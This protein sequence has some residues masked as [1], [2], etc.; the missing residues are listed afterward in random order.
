MVQLSISP[1][2]E[3]V[4]ISERLVAS[5]EADF[6]LR[7]YADSLK[8]GQR[9]F[10]RF[11]AGKDTSIVGRTRT[12][13]AHGKVASFNFATLACQSY[14]QGFYGTLARMIKEDEIA[15]EEE[16]ID[17]VFHL[18][19]F[20]YEVV[21]DD[22]RNDNHNPKWLIDRNGNERAI[23]PF[24]EGKQWPD[25]DHWKSGSWSPITVQDYRHL[26]KT[27]L[28]NKV[29][30]EA[31]ARWPFVVTWDDHEFADGNHQSHS[32]IAKELGMY[33]MQSVKVAANQAWYEYI[34]AA[35]DHAT[36]FPDLKK[37]SHDFKPTEVR[38]TDL[39]VEIVNGLYQEPNNIKAINSLCIYRALRWGKDILLVIPDTKSYNK[40]G[41]SVFGNEQKKW[42]K[43]IINN[44]D[45]KW[46]LWANSEPILA[47]KVDFD[48]IPAI[49]KERSLV[50]NDSWRQTPQERE[51]LL[52]YIENENITGVVSLS[53]DYHTQMAST[54]P[55]QT[56][57]HVMADFAVTAM[58]AFPDLLWLERRG[59]SYNN[60]QAY[61]LFAYQDENGQLLPNINTT[62]MY[63]VKTAAKLAKTRDFEQAKTLMDLTINPGL[64]Y[65]DCQYNGYITGGIKED[66]LK[67]EFVNTENA[68]IDYE[69]TGAS[70]VSKVLFELPLWDK[71]DNISLS[72][73][74][75]EGNVFP[76]FE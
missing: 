16:K 26:Y 33:G 43:A 65:F 59:K 51:E 17:L 54:V 49:G 12:A 10:Y 28:S 52:S 11:I 71:V 50:N 48:N 29:M 39:G 68:R 30:I 58:S 57:K 8:S 27:Y 35:L 31:R 23:Q 18:G 47:A 41:Y 6:T 56:G 70:I 2:F 37:A 62:I 42:F 36:K 53:G 73:P 72:N 74:K 63:G 3:E 66:L 55:T 25:T 22:P 5:Q 45:V 13:P 4:I 46:K 44:S 60:P 14:E 1:A 69:A 20:I 64:K 34:P 76:G 7:Y 24:P 15:P 40:P 32:D 61:E 19:D 21:G 75:I 9:Y 38:N 67:V